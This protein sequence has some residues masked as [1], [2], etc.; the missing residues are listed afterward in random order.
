MVVTTETQPL[1]CNV[2]DSAQ[3]T[4]TYTKPRHKDTKRA[5]AG[6][7]GDTGNGIRKN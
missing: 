7:M 5:P 2:L 4:Q 3:C 6:E 1:S